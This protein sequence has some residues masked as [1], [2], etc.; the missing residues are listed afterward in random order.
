MLQKIRTL[1][2]Q[3]E[4]TNLEFLESKVLD[5]AVVINILSGPEQQVMTNAAQESQTERH[6]MEEKTSNRKEPD[7]PFSTNTCQMFNNLGMFY[8]LRLETTDHLGLVRG[9]DLSA[10][11]NWTEHFSSL[12]KVRSGFGKI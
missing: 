3:I 4:R 8:T 6:S 10:P 5:R 2:R 9:P 7:C 11:F 12:F 1:A